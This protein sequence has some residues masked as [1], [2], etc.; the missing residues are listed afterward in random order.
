MV[1]PV[2]ST[3]VVNVSWSEVQCFNGSKA[4]SHYLVQY[5]SLCGGA[6]QSVTTNGTVQNV[7]GL[8]PNCVYTFRVAAVGVS[9]KIGR[10]SSPV[11]TSLPGEC[12]RQIMLDAV[13]SVLTIILNSVA[14]NLGGNM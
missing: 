10:F 3:A 2:N 12:R 14:Q 7:S 11:N 5:Q 4:V 8:I 6:V 13:T 9:Q 1:I